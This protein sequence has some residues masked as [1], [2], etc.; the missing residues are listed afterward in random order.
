M[1]I[2]AAR[3]DSEVA[4]HD[5]NIEAPGDDRQFV[6]VSS[7]VLFGRKENTAIIQENTTTVEAQEW[8]R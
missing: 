8:V 3:M 7:E 6:G 2:P 1:S 5:W 4:S